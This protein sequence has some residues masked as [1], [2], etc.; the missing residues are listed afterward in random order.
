VKLTKEDKLRKTREYTEEKIITVLKE[1]E[2]GIS[3]TGPCCK[4]NINDATYH[5][6]YHLA[7]PSVK[8][9]FFNMN[10][11]RK[12]SNTDAFKADDIIEYN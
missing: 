4:Y 5:V 8:A 6:F 2:A 10:L 1:G 9:T 12:W 11:M 3:V 7:I